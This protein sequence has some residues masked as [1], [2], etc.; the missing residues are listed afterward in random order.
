M[1]AGEKTP[2]QLENKFQQAIKRCN[3]QKRKGWAHIHTLKSDGWEKNHLV[4]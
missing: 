4:S 1:C 2:N 3:G